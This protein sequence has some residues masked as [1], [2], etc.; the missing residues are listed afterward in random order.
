MRHNYQLCYIRQSDYN[1]RRHRSISVIVNGCLVKFE[2]GL[3]ALTGLWNI[4]ATDLVNSC[5]F[6]PLLQSYIVQ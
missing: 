4:T 6:Q 2:R 3:E 5:C 1:F